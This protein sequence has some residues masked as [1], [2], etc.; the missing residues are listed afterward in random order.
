MQKTPSSTRQSVLYC[1]LL[2]SSY[3]TT[4]VRKSERTPTTAPPPTPTM[5]SHCPPDVCYRIVT[6]STAFAT[7]L[8]YATKS[9]RIKT[10]MRENPTSE[11]THCVS[12]SQMRYQQIVYW[13]ANHGVFYLFCFFF[14]IY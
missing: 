5:R 13:F 12:F 8:F 11:R 6:L 7:K 1:T 4:T 14:S 2:S 3:E 9:I 10:Y